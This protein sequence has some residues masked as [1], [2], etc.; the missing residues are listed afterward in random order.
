MTAKI[1]FGP[2]TRIAISVP[3]GPYSVCWKCGDPPYENGCYDGRCRATCGD[4]P[5]GGCGPHCDPG[6][7]INAGGS[8]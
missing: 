6:S 7:E 1:V 8:P 4:C 3:G 5:P 2:S